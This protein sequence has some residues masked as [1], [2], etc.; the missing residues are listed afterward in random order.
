LSSSSSSSGAV[1]VQ[2]LTYHNDVARTGQNLQET[3]LTP[4][5]VNS[6]AFGKLASLSTQGKV[7]AEPLYV[8]GLSIGGAVHNVV[9]VVTEHDMAYAFDADSFAPL[10]QRSVLSGG[11]S[12]SDQRNCNQVVPEIGITATPV[13]DPGAGPHGSLYLAAMSRDSGGAYHQ[14][15][16]ALDLASGAELDGG[17]SEIQASYARTGGS[18][19]FDPAQYEERAA[20]LQIGGNIYLSWTS[21]CDIDPYSAWVMAYSGSTLQQTA[22]INLTPNGSEGSVW[23]AGAGPAADSAGNIYAL[24]ANGSFDTTL[25]A[26][27]FPSKGDYGNAFVKLASAGGALAVADYFSMSNTEAESNADQDLGSGGT[28]VLPDLKDGSGNTRHLAVGAGKDASIYLVNRDAMG[29]FSAADNS[30]IYQQVQ[31][32]SNGLGGAEFGMPAYFNNTLYYGAVNDRLKAFPLAGARIGAPSSKTSASFGYPGTTPGISANGTA[33]GI[34][35]AV[36]NGSTA[37]LHAYD[38][39]N[40]ASELYNS[41]QAGSRDQFAGNKFITPMIA[42]GRVYVGT[43]S[44]V[45]VF[46]LLH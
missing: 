5:N 2:V 1:T 19:A 8:P 14:R 35:W 21:H 13:I 4:A 26:A 18:V 10:W 29:K 7:D 33:S 37:I 16:H 46:G 22:V 39:A 45:A 28:L 31:G 32:G 44:G 11:E 20:L 27:G 25:N 17:P 34:V 41:N 43:P 40:L 38:A 12:P 6:G 24:I 15:L 30:A 9:F 3:I 23:M 42:N 36:T